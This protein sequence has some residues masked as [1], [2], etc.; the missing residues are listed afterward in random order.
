MVV[1]HEIFFVNSTSKQKQNDQN[2]EETIFKE[3]EDEVSLIPEE[4]IR[5]KIVQTR[6]GQTKFKQR[7]MRL[8]VNVNYVGLT[9]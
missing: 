2:A 5:E 1:L 8:D 9:I 6:I 7:P 3:I 4:T